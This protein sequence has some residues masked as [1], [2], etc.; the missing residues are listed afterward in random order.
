MRRRA[1]DVCTVSCKSCAGEAL[2]YREDR[3]SPALRGWP[4]T[5]SGPGMSRHVAVWLD[6]HE[7]KLFHVKPG[8][9]TE[10][11]LKAPHASMHQRHRDKTH[12]SELKHYFDE[13]THGL[14]EAEEIL[15]LGP[16]PTKLQLF[17][18]L[19]EHHA[20]VGK[21]VV[22]LETVDH[23]TDGQIVAHARTYFARFDA[24]QGQGTTLD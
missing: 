21:R 11:H 15:L 9:F 14:A 24:L 10:E 20:Q 12:P 22:G 17:K 1:T 4:G 6:H 7:A 5:C 19:Q 16:G 18:H 2:P 3:E 23:P 8:A 13:V